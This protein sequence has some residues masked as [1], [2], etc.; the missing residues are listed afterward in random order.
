[1][2]SVEFI[3]ILGAAGVALWVIYLITSGKLH[4]NSEVEGLKADKLVLLAENKELRGVNAETAPLLRD[5]LTILR[6]EGP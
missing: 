2:P 6:D 5:I 1:M 4:T 3:T